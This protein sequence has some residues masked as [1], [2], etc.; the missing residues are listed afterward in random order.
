MRLRVPVLLFLAATGLFA[1]ATQGKPAD[2]PGPKK[3]AAR[4]KPAVGF[5][6]Q[7]PSMF[8]DPRFVGLETRHARLNVPW[9]VLR[10]PSTRANVDA[11]MAGARRRGRLPRVTRDRARRRGMEIPPPTPRVL[12]PPGRPGRARGAR[13]GNHKSSWNEGNINKRP[14]VVARVLRTGRGCSPGARAGLHSTP[15]GPA[16]VDQRLSARGPPRR[17][18]A[19]RVS[20]AGRR[21]RRFEVAPRSPAADASAPGRRE[22][23][24]AWRRKRRWRS[25][26]GLAMRE[27]EERLADEL[28]RPGVA[29]EGRRGA[30]PRAQRCWAPSA[31]FR[32]RGV[33]GEILELAEPRAE[34]E[35]AAARPPSTSSVADERLPAPGRG[36]HRRAARGG[37]QR[38]RPPAGGRVCRVARI[39]A[40]ARPSR[41]WTCSRAW[42]ALEVLR[43]ERGCAAMEDER[44]SS[45]CCWPGPRRSSPP[46]SRSC[47]RRAAVPRARR[48]LRTRAR[49]MPPR[50]MCSAPS[51]SSLRCATSRSTRRRPRF[52]PHAK[53][54]GARGGLARARGAAGA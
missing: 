35:R 19:K 39:V 1:P 50:T 34:A 54:A 8:A 18:R 5:A 36:G 40:W 33:R 16:R 31:S 37:L 42:A 22:P 49:M 41:R 3:R 53:S 15:A 27:F 30:A 43:A 47:R 45:A 24:S 26:A 51:C 14:E 2:D 4:T 9:D 12:T 44:R 17:R 20:A 21:P 52:I 11:W 7:K 28:R 32:G 23:E 29:A 6:D 13:P 10:D 38:G 48:H 25:P 46:P